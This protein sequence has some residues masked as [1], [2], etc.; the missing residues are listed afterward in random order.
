MPDL[1]SL[2][3]L[4]SLQGDAPAAPPAEPPFRLELALDLWMP[5]L[6]GEFNDGGAKVDVRDVDPYNE[7]VRV[8]GKG[9]KERIVPV[10]EPALEAIQ[11]YRA[12]AKV[13]SGPLFLSKLRR[14]MGREVLLRPD[15][16][17]AI[18]APHAQMVDHA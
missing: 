4:G 14:R 6:E 10:G 3:L 9:S 18:T 12:R 2:I 13:P 8:L 15:P 5:R 17:I 11:Q 1:A 16:A 7:T